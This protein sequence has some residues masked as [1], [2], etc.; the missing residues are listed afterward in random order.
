MK[1]N[2]PNNKIDIPE[3]Y[4]K[5]ASKNRVNRIFSTFELFQSLKLS[6]L[7]V[8]L[9]NSFF[10]STKLCKT[11]YSDEKKHTVAGPKEWKD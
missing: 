6:L 7:N 4:S 11:K 1:Q 5:I 9:K 3:L 8:I 10:F 2:K